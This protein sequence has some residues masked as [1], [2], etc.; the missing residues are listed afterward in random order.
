MVKRQRHHIKQV[1][2]EKSNVLTMQTRPKIYCENSTHRPTRRD[3]I[4]AQPASFRFSTDTQRKSVASPNRSKPTLRLPTH[5]HFCQRSNYI[6][7]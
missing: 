6:Q 1:D 7:L 5:L 3:L 4:F 2:K